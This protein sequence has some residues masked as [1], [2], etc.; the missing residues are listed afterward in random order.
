MSLLR[1]AEPNLLS[2]EEAY[3]RLLVLKTL[4]VQIVERV[5][6]AAISPLEHPID[7]AIVLGSLVALGSD[8]LVHVLGHGFDELDRKPMQIELVLIAVGLEPG[9]RDVGGLL[10]DGDDLQPDHVRWV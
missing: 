5:A 7:V 4:L 6:T 2:P 1:Q 9:V 3:Q 10:A 8:P